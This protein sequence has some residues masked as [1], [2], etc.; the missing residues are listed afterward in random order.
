MVA[1]HAYLILVL[2]ERLSAKPYS[3][4][5]VYWVEWYANAM[6]FSWGWRHVTIADDFA[7]IATEVSLDIDMVGTQ[8]TV[9]LRWPGALAAFSV[10]VTYTARYHDI[11][12]I[13]QDLH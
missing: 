2:P 8:V 7:L 5:L 6:S 11:E 12:V 9:P 10:F 3:C 4:I 13:T 1:I